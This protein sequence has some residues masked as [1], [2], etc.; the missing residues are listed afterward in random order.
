MTSWEPPEKDKESTLANEE[1]VPPEKDKESTGISGISSGWEPPEKDDP[2][3]PANIK[4]PLKLNA[5]K[6]SGQSLSE[7][8]ERIVFDWEDAKPISKR[9]SEFTAKAIPAAA[10]S[11]KDIAVGGAEF[12]YKGILMPAQDIITGGLY[13][14]P[15]EREKIWREQ[16]LS[17]K[18]LASGGAQGLDEAIEAGTR[19]ASFG[20]AITDRIQ[21]LPKEQRF[22][23]YMMRENMRKFAQAAR[24]ETPD[25][26]ARLASESPLIQKMVTTIVGM[27]GGDPEAQKVAVEEY[28]KLVKE[29]GMTKEELEEFSKVVNFGD[30]K[31]PTSI[32]GANTV[33]AAISKP[34]TAAT[35]KAGEVTLK[36]L[37]LGSR[38][39]GWTAGKTIKGGEWIQQKSKDIG[40]Y[41]VNDPD[42]FVKT[43]TNTLLA[44]VMLV[45][46]PTKSVA[47]VITDITRQVDK[48]GAAGRKGMI[49]RA[50][51]DIRS[52]ELTRKLFG[53]EG[54]GGVG[55]AKAADWAIRQSN[56]MIQPGVSSGTL[57]VLMGL[58]DAETAAQAGQQF[59]TGF[60][61][62]AYAGSRVESR[63]GGLIDPRTTAAS[64]ISNL[65][66]PDPTQLRRD[67]DADIKRFMA[68]ASPELV[69]Q[70]RDLS[71]VDKRKVAVDTRI[72][73]LEDIQART[74]N[75]EDSKFIQDQIDGFKKQ[76]EALDKATPETQREYDRLVQ[77]T[78]LDITDQAKSVGLAAGLR[79]LNLVFLDPKNAEPFY[80]NLYGQNL[81]D[82]EK[83]MA[84]L[85]NKPFM[86]PD[87]ENTLRQANETMSAFYQDV[88]NLEN[89]RGTS[90][91]ESV[92]DP[93][94]P[95]FVPPHLRYLN[96]QGATAVVNMDLVKH[97][98]R[99]G[100]NVR[101]TMQ[102]E[103]QHALENFK[104][105][106][107][108]LSPL[109]KY[110]FDQK[111]KTADGGIEVAS[112]GIYDDEK[113][114]A[115]T[116]E[117][118]EK[119]SPQDGGVSFIAQFGGDIDKQRNYIK[120]EILSE[121]SAIAGEYRDG[122]RAVL[123]D[124]GRKAI[125]WLE[126][127]TRDGYLKKLKEGLRTVGVVFDNGGG[128]S[129]LLGA[130]I[131]PE[132]LSAV[133]EYQR[134][135]RDIN[136]ALTYNQREE[137]DEP[138]IPITT[139]LGNRA[140]QEK[141][142]EVAPFELEPVV[143]VT[144]P[145]GSISEI[146]VPEGANLDSLVGVY[147]IKDGKFIDEDGNE[148]VLAPE[149]NISAMPDGT[150][151][152]INTRIA[153]KPDGTPITISNREMKRR[154]IDRTK[155]LIDAVNSA[156][157]DDSPYRMIDIGNGNYSGAMSPSQVEALRKIP[158]LILSPNLKRKIEFL[159]DILRR[160]DG[161]RVSMEYQASLL[162]G[163]YQA[164][165]PKLRDEV[166]IGFKITKDGNFTLTTMSV[167]RMH[168]KMNAWASKK[169]MRLQAWGGDTGKFWDSVIKYL[170]NHAQ[171]KHGE[172]GLDPDPYISLRKKYAI[173]DLFNVYN[174]ETKAANPER[175]TLP[176]QKGKD[177]IDI[178]VRSR[179]LDR[180][181]DYSEMSAQKLPMNYGKLRDNY[182]PE[183]NP[184]ARPQSPE[185]MMENLDGSVTATRIRQAIASGNVEQLESELR[186]SDDLLPFES[187]YVSQGETGEP[188][189][190][191]VSMLDP[192]IEPSV[193]RS[194]IPTDIDAETEAEMS[195]LD[196]EYDM[197][198]MGQQGQQEQQQGQLGQLEQK[199]GQQ[200]QQV[201]MARAE[202][203]PPQE[204]FDD[205]LKEQ[206]E[207]MYHGSP[208]VESLEKSGFDISKAGSTSGY[209][210]VYGT[211]VYLTN[212]SKR[213]EL[214]GTPIDIIV[215]PDAK[216]W[217]IEAKDALNNLFTSATKY[218]DPDLIR[219]LA[220]NKGYDGIEITNSEVGAKETV[221]FDPSKIKTRAQLEA[222]FKEKQGK[223]SGNTPRQINQYMPAF[224]SDE[225]G[226]EEGQEAE[227]RLTPRTLYN[228]YYIATEPEPTSEYGRKITN[229]YIDKY[230]NLYIDVFSNLARQQIEKYIGR[231]RVDSNVTEKAL[232]KADTP[233]ML[234]ELMRGTY[235]SDMRRRNDVWNTVTEHLKNLSG[236]T[237]KKDKIFYMDRLNNSIHNT[238]ELLFSKFSNYRQL[239]EAFDSIH[240]ARDTRAYSQRV[241]KDLREFNSF[242]GTQYMPYV[243]YSMPKDPRQI[244][245]DF[246]LLTAVGDKAGYFGKDWEKIKAGQMPTRAGLR[247]E[248]YGPNLEDAVKELTSG[249]KKH[250]LDSLL[251]SI[252]AEL[253]HYKSNRQPDQLLD[254][255]FMKAYSEIY[256]AYNA[257]SDK[258]L[259]EY[260]QKYLKPMYPESPRARITKGSSKGYQLSN[261]AVRKALEETGTTIEDFS[262]IV[263]KLFRKGNWNSSYGGNPW[264]NIAEGLRMVNQANDTESLIKSIDNAYDLQH[265]TATV[266]NKIKKY[267]REGGYQWLQDMLDFK[268]HAASPRELTPMA[269][270]AA[271]KITT[272]ALMDIGDNTIDK[273]RENAV[274]VIGEDVVSE[275]EKVMKAL[276]PNREN[277]Y[278]DINVKAPKGSG[279]DINAELQKWLVNSTASKELEKL[280]VNPDVIQYARLLLAQ[281]MAPKRNV[282]QDIK[283]LVAESFK[284]QEEEYGPPIGIPK[285]KIAEQKNI[286]WKPFTKSDWEGFSGAEQ[287]PE[288][289]KTT[290]SDQPILGEMKMLVNGKEEDVLLVADANGLNA[291][292]DEGSGYVVLSDNFLNQDE[293][294]HYIN[295][296]INQK[297]LYTLLTA[298]ASGEAVFSQVPEQ[299]KESGKKLPADM[300][301]APAKAGGNIVP[302]DIG[303]LNK[304]IHKL[305][306]LHT[307]S[308][309]GT[310][311]PYK[312]LVFSGMG[313]IPADTFT[314][315][316][317]KDGT[318]I[319]EA[320]FNM[321]SPV[322]D[323]AVN[324][325]LEANVKEEGTKS[326]KLADI[327][328][329]VKEQTKAP[330]LDKFIKWNP[331]Y[332][333]KG[334][335]E[336]FENGDKPIV[337]EMTAYFNGKPLSA[338]FI[339]TGNGLYIKTEKGGE[340]SVQ[341]TGASAEDAKSIF[342][343]H[344]LGKYT[345]ISDDMKEYEDVDFSFTPPKP[346]S[347][348]Q[349]KAPSSE[350]SLSPDLTPIAMTIEQLKQLIVNPETG[351]ISTQPLKILIK[352]EL[353]YFPPNKIEGLTKWGNMYADWAKKAPAEELWPSVTGKPYENPDAIENVYS[354]EKAIADF[355]EYKKFQYDQ[356]YANQSKKLKGVLPDEVVNTILDSAWIQNEKGSTLE[357]PEKVLEKVKSKLGD[358]YNSL[359]SALLSTGDIN[360]L[361]NSINSA[362]KDAAKTMF[363][364]NPTSLEKIPKF[365]NSSQVLELAK[366]A[367]EGLAWDDTEGGESV[368][369]NL[370]E[371]F[372]DLSDE[373]VEEL[374]KWYNAVLDY[375]NEKKEF[376]GEKETTPL[377]QKPYNIEKFWP[378]SLEFM[379]PYEID[380][381]KKSITDA[382]AA[383]KNSQ[384]WL[385][386]FEM[387]GSKAKDAYSPDS[388]KELKKVFDEEA[389]KNKK[390]YKL[391]IAEAEDYFQKAIKNDANYGWKE[392]VD[393]NSDWPSQLV[394][395]LFHS[396]LDKPEFSAKNRTISIGEKTYTAYT[397]NKNGDIFILYGDYNNS[398]E[399]MNYNWTGAAQ[400]KT[401]NR[402]REEVV[403]ELAEWLK[404][405]VDY[406][407]PQI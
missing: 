23:R 291:Y 75:P 198:E 277:I 156:P 180:I 194:E 398:G 285:K 294:I 44:P 370:G 113:I 37:N 205:W 308:D 284:T 309:I 406:Y 312:G 341:F 114:D 372:G 196:A 30:V 43:A 387:Y 161:T 158:N 84:V 91:R 365:M 6:Q 166:P 137:I 390:P 120:R 306:H 19:M 295:D 200:G 39:T 287:F 351:E 148:M 339:L 129:E 82:A 322:Y 233:A 354:E 41:A 221:I 404:G 271:Q 254:N 165:S 42:T 141:Y 374:K 138:D 318:K 118:A 7:D 2:D 25:T 157:K 163:R 64:K 207:F 305:M 209:K 149:I 298:K 368:S 360:F 105:V 60:G 3:D 107:D 369:D 74:I 357:T 391:R 36:G 338:A 80:R 343:K 255:P 81:I 29:S 174:A 22:R 133:R 202:F 299:V 31:M 186:M 189:I 364:A 11:V 162:N 276:K 109:R 260:A 399:D 251:F 288:K 117:Y 235:R 257:V 125:D 93:E 293:A 224:N 229:E 325:Y 131:T 159:N 301:P 246:Y 127:K 219:E 214:Y 191:V 100:F 17:T 57:N 279:K 197:A 177:P 184:L 38:A 18:A 253:R 274:S 250:M 5:L 55:R 108:L 182:M 345:D 49:Q 190:Q 88:Q 231:G 56:A 349:T 270:S 47:D 136:G 252:S 262:N 234:D 62:G 395:T 50:G 9:A 135:V 179:R 264:G 169:P 106:Q 124:V 119:F 385:D 183:I 53:R 210:G 307:E 86:T 173:N 230:K 103:V 248:K 405:E 259:P 92:T 67:Q 116:A 236:A 104:E 407:N 381:T 220:V 388:Q 140:L 317:Y 386:G 211:G 383:G 222:Q 176:R 33:T 359:M 302:A 171:G 195:R 52:S 353:K 71:S 244:M 310:M 139:I 164:L 76:K 208:N 72:S 272:P 263:E 218:G 58:P 267:Q 16:Q 304:E 150:Q 375:E 14:S 178:I 377:S 247:Y 212:E 26:L 97:L 94:S 121:I 313:N 327:P 32:P 185:D 281:K 273:R 346:A 261:A 27:Q 203:I 378:Q 85:K 101:H 336:N 382:I 87:E 98:T 392:I 4:D 371:F 78:T 331:L 20:S 24:D 192:G 13:Y 160:G 143:K 323:K 223:L 168:D 228:L 335:Y 40:Q 332:S 232:D 199:Q 329:P 126:V 286:N 334:E 187:L 241:D 142:K 152:Q 146:K 227:N 311:V 8:Q 51:D 337:T 268:Y 61:M 352:T 238:Q 400:F 134:G 154:A 46:K 384:A 283:D 239:Q 215:S 172:E 15:E 48:G 175:T 342:I 77:L 380:Y 389:K 300:F 355:K 256:D 275:I 1:W 289:S 206:G 290:N 296:A 245:A 348:A 79:G 130:K 144:Q 226:L 217:K 316:T 373:N 366:A 266:F 181:N 340:Y 147:R 89:S 35:R 314:I 45:A 328:A 240:N 151:F 96:Q 356:W 66:T 297:L 303:A 68:T 28:E 193:E 321:K 367:K 280:G 204:S 95:D 216:L 34:L 330:V 237:T 83:A 54:K 21:G 70:M 319:D 397:P 258:N 145:D 396:D 99:Q 269:S 188:Q 358:S 153:R 394:Y 376:Y 225:Y 402:T 90:V 128:Y 361:N 112:K 333:P 249:M 69:E 110:L 315:K 265:N 282:P 201:P 362:I 347:L 65:V 393:I 102:H 167:S 132:V 170:D 243:P 115:Y 326:D 344:M 363:S 63:V 350:P 123:D 320:V 292:Y 10:E 379:S 122:S 12:G 59:G 111:V 278:Q 213:A 324:A 403:A 242:R 155:M 73:E 401:E